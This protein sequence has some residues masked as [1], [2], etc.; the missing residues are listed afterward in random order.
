[1]KA[2]RRLWRDHSEVVVLMALGAASFALLYLCFWGI[3]SA[4]AEGEERERKSRLEI[5][6]KAE[7]A[8]RAAA[9]SNRRLDEALAAIEALKAATNTASAHVA[10][11]EEREKEQTCTCA[12]EAKRTREENATR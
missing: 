10:E 12:G 7:A 8:E 6:A 2:I 11:A 3:F 4:V 1:M 9:E 5:A